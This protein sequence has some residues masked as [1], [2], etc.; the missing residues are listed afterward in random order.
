MRNQLD[1]LTRNTHALAHPNLVRLLKVTPD[2]QYF[3]DAL[4]LARSQ[5]DGHLRDRTRGATH[6]HAQSVHPWWARGQKPVVTIGDH[7]FYRGVE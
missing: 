1:Q 4:V 2:V 5:V 6:Y 3:A 7:V